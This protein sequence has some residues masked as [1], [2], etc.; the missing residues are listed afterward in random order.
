MPSAKTIASRSAGSASTTQI[1]QSFDGVE[2]PVVPPA[3]D[4][5]QQVGHD[6][7]EDERCRLPPRDPPGVLELLLAHLSVFA[8]PAGHTYAAQERET[9]A[10]NAVLRI[11]SRR[12][13]Q[14]V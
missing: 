14:H 12:R 3:P 7:D 2:L 13:A 5:E 4:R 11:H 9:A 1:H 10:V 8:V 6:G